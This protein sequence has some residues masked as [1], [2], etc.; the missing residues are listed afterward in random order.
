MNPLTSA[1]L[2]GLLEGHEPPCV[3]LYQPTNRVGPDNQQDRVR[4]RNLLKEAEDALGRQYPAREVRPLLEPFAALVDDGVFWKQRL[5]GLAIFGAPGTFRVF[6]LPQEVPARVIVADSFHTKP[7]VRYLQSADRFQ[8]LGL[9][10]HQATLYEGNRYGLDLTELKG[11]PGVIPKEGPEEQ[12]VPIPTVGSYGEGPTGPGHG[13]SE[14]GIAFGHSQSKGDQVDADTGRFFRAVDRA[15]LEHHS[16][17]SGLPLMLAALPQYHAAFRKLT[18]NPFLIDAGIERDPAGLS[19]DALCREAW[20]R[21]EPR[22]RQRLAKLVDDFQEARS[23]QKGADALDQ[24]AAAL[25]QGR[26]GTLLVERD[27]QV[28][29]TLDRAD[30]TIRLA[31]AADPGVDD[32]LDDLAEA[33]LGTGGQVVV[34]PADRMPTTTG[35]AAIYR[36]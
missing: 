25:A 18:H 21:M 8:V 13:H 3:S 19:A 10:R 17:P 32:L 2:A 14:P 35:A 27:R 1:D 28:P 15:V 24:I 26:V 29:G 12:T 34:V 7:L 22:Y 36:Y 4:Y 16:R 11:L 5:D 30:G 20:E 6:K 23:K 33:T 9:S 31:E